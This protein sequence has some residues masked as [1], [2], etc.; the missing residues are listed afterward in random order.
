MIPA[1]LAHLQYPAN[2]RLSFPLQADT[3]KH[4]LSLSGICHERLTGRDEKAVRRPVNVNAQ[5]S[6]ADP[7]RL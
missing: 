7:H 1:G 4:V 2:N 5:V 3:L 6:E